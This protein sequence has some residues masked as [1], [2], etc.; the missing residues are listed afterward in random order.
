MELLK[1]EF[2]ECHF[3]VFEDYPTPHSSSRFFLPTFT[4]QLPPMITAILDER[5]NLRLILSKAAYDRIIS[6]TR[7]GVSSSDIPSFFI[8]HQ[9]MFSALAYLWPAEILTR[10]VNGFF[11]SKYDG[12]IVPDNELGAATLSGKLSRSSLSATRCRSCYSGIL[13]STRKIELDEDLDYLVIISGPEPQRTKLE[14]I[15]LQQVG[16]LPERKVVLLGSPKRCFTRRPDEDAIVKSYVPLGVKAELMNRARFVISRSGY[17]TMMVVEG[18][19]KRHGLFVPT[20]GQTE[21]E[22][23][24]RYYGNR[25]WFLLWSQYGLDLGRDVDEAMDFS[26]FLSMPKT[27]ENVTRLY[28]E[29]LAQHLE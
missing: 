25:G 23:L 6:A 5:R 4:A 7:L 29:L 24:S 16:D 28:E 12:V 2:P 10:F 13:R 3:V 27:E 18:L 22:Y 20:P 8:T 14:E 1:I 21:Q 11:H 17:T 15:V 26:G 19:E 9:L